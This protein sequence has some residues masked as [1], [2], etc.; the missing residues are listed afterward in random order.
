[1]VKLF[2]SVPPDN[3]KNLPS[4]SAVTVLLSFL[5][6]VRTPSPVLNEADVTKVLSPVLVTNPASL[7][8]LYL[9]GY[10][11][12]IRSSRRLEHLTCCNLEVIWLIEGVRPTYKTIA[13][14][15]QTNPQAFVKINVDFV[16]LCKE[17]N[18]LGG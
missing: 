8:K 15:R 7:L 6:R 9:Y 1:M 12:S 14:F 11:N 10:Q 17:L 5:V 3:C 4:K 16:M 13:N 18:L 2:V